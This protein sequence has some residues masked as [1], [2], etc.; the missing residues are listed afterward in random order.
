ML[1]LH[2]SNSFNTLRPV[3]Q[4]VLERNKPENPLEPFQVIVPNRDTGRWL[5]LNRA[6]GKGIS[7]QWEMTLPA[8]FIHQLNLLHNPNYEQH[9]ATKQKL[10][11][12]LFSLFR[13]GLEEPEFSQLRE[14]IT[15][16][17]RAYQLA[18][19]IADAFDQYMLF[20]PDWILNWN[21]GK[22]AAISHKEEHWQRLLWQKIKKRNPEL[23]DRAQLHQQL[24]EFLSSGTSPKDEILF[25]FSPGI[26]P[27]VYHEVFKSYSQKNDVHW[28]RLDYQQKNIPQNTETLFKLF[29][30]EK[31][32]TDK[33]F[34]NVFDSA[35]DSINRIESPEINDDKNL[36]KLQRS[37]LGLPAAGAV[38]WDDTFRVHACHNEF[39][40]VEVL[41]EHILDFL[42]KD[43]YASPGDVLVVTPDIAK[44]TG[45]VNAVF[46]KPEDEKLFIPYHIND[47]ALSGTIRI[48]RLI[49]HILT[50]Q[51]T[52]FTVS[53]VLAVIEN[54]AVKTKFGISNDDLNV[55]EYWVR[56]TGIRWGAD[57]TQRNDDGIHSWE[58]G[59]DRLI[60]GLMMPLDYE[61]IALETSPFVDLDGSEAYRLIGVLHSITDK[62]KNW[63][64]FASQKHT[65]NTWKDEL[66]DLISFFIPANAEYA[67]ALLPIEKQINNLVTALSL[68]LDAAVSLDIILDALSENIEKP[69]AGSA[70][71]YG[72]VTFTP[73]VPVRNLPFKFIAVLGLNESE[74]PGSDKKSSFD[75]M[76]SDVRPGDRSIRLTNRGLIMDAVLAAS[77]RLHLSYTGYS[78]KDGS[79]IPPSI[80]VT[81]LAEQLCKGSELNPDD[82]TVRHRLHAF[83]RD[84]FPKN[85]HPNWFS[86]HPQRKTKAQKLLDFNQASMAPERIDGPLKIT[87]EQPVIIP[88]SELVKS[89]RMPVN[90]LYE[91]RLNMRKAREDEIPEDRDLFSFDGLQKWKMNQLL[92]RHISAPDA[93]DFDELHRKLRASGELIYGEA[94]KR[95][96]QQK[97]DEAQKFW[98]NV[99]EADKEFW[100]LEKLKIEIPSE[101]NGLEVVI[102]GGVQ[103]GM[104]NIRVIIDPSKMNASRKMK[105]W[106][107]HLA[108]CTAGEYRTVCHTYSNWNKPLITHFSYEEKADTLLLKI[109]ST[110]LSES[111]DEVPVYP[112]ILELAYEHKYGD[113]S[114][115]QKIEDWFEHSDADYAQN[116]YKTDDYASGFYNEFKQE[117]FNKLLHI[118]DKIW[119]PMMD[120]IKGIKVDGTN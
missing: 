95:D 24:L 55:L 63:A 106:L 54:E 91:K 116:V 29:G 88:L 98:D 59:L 85:Q 89:A 26:I 107:E 61:G 90:W 41:H 114:Q 2:V 18:A 19:V 9:L 70:Y 1:E 58:F 20:R 37:M 62:L 79:E 31:R 69:R 74:F 100:T 30:E 64:A 103:S 73:M 21:S 92:F 67:K 72:G 115:K 36:N 33:A 112:E 13:E 109:A 84:Y 66:S 6:S 22:K 101:I 78:R 50:I 10:T 53:A 3:F 44:Y 35:F 57:A 51:S 34:L 5:Q 83:H 7:A 110:M 4:E 42:S 108:A 32:Q 43:K 11:W 117:W 104:S 96:L 52:G 65:L 23:V 47:P 17:L 49:K 25:I 102:R 27:P 39:R 12:I 94:G 80:V 68:I 46:G 111:T 120:N 60:S 38:S 99:D 56:E 118:S 14:Y 71:R 45:A 77:G 81:E 75:L 82:C 97:M 8:A 119:K 16:E 28:F 76:S 113:K 86:F 40:E 105:L 48:F 87:D 15:G 93:L